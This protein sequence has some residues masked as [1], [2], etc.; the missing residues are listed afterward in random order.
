MHLVDD[1]ESPAT[2]EYATEHEYRGHDIGIRNIC[3]EIPILWSV[4][5]KLD[6]CRFLFT[7]APNTRNNSRTN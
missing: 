2:N 1:V 5:E 7:L 6:T 4:R 3:T